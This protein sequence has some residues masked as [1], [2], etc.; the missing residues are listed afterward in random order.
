MK[1]INSLAAAFQATPFD[2]LYYLVAIVTVFALFYFVPLRKVYE[3]AFGAVVGLGIYILLR[4]L[5]FE[6]SSLWT[7]GWLLPFW[8]SVFIISIAIYFVIIL[9][10]LFPLNW[11]LV[12][13]ETTNPVLY[14][15]QYIFLGFFVFIGLS[16]VLV[17]MIEQTYIF[18][19]WTIFSWVRE[20]WFYQNT[21]RL[22]NVFKFIMT[23]QNI[24]IPLGV[25]LMIYKI[26]LSNI[27]S[28]IVLSIVYNLSK[29][30]LYRKKEESSYRVEFHEIGS[31][32][33]EWG[34]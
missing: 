33:S 14:V 19:V 17:Y 9:A 27:V 16:A 4:A 8:V 11:S 15:A 29:V 7:T 20:W 34:E 32:S 1:F 22:S 6:N 21:I 3:V 18:Q 23:H 26:F 2:V 31:E 28:A 24:I 5:L 10:I 25:L 30:G 12:I 13:S